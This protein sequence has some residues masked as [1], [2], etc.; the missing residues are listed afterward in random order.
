MRF[1]RKN[2][3]LDIGGN[4]LIKNIKALLWGARSISGNESKSWEL[5]GLKLLEKNLNSQILPDGMH[6]ELS[7]VYHNQV[8][9]DLIEVYLILRDGV[10]KKKLAQTLR[11]M[12]QVCLDFKHPDG[13]TSQFNDGGYSYTYSAG[14]LLKA[15]SKVFDD[16]PIQ[17]NHIIMKSSGY[18]GFRDV[19]NL[20]IIDCGPLSAPDLPAHGH[21]DALAIEWSISGERFLIDAGVYEY[22]EGELRAYSR[23]T[24]AHNTVTINDEDQSEFWKSFRVGRRANIINCEYSK[25]SKGFK[26]H[27][28]HDGYSR[29]KGEPYHERK[30]KYQPGLLNINDIIVGQSNYKVLSNFL[31]HPDWEIILNNNKHVILKSKKTTIN[32]KSSHQINLNEALWHPDHGL[33]ISTTRLSINWG[34]VASSCS[35]KFEHNK[36]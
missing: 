28:S 33:E 22:N 23:S 25:L 4:H 2:L 7:P 9:A 21:G 12:A 1:L 17:N 35:I 11:K 30:V 29:L 31:I 20:I 34:P 13:T 19:D 6:Y 5:K 16:Y 10:I 3:E 8:F 36:N 26:F 24:A 32:M 18:Y 15:Y 27:G 14:D